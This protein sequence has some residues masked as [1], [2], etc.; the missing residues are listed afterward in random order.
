MGTNE[1]LASA[2]GGGEL[3]G[4]YLRWRCSAMMLY[5]RHI[6][7][8]GRYSK[9]AISLPVIASYGLSLHR[10]IPHTSIFI[11]SMEIH[12]G[13]Q[14]SDV[15]YGIT[16]AVVWTKPRIYFIPVSVTKFSIR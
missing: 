3:I 12:S 14:E 1:D 16:I 9:I 5:Q 7:W 6:A 13:C 15:V 8:A 11:P 4:Y 2:A 10:L